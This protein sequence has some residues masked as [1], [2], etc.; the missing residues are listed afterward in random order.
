M[1]TET[2]SIEQLKQLKANFEQAH[3]DLMAAGKSGDYDKMTAAF[4]AEALAKTAVSRA[5]ADI[6][7]AAQAA[8]QERIMAIT[9]KA[10]DRIVKVC[11]TDL[12]ELVEQTKI[13]TLYIRY[14]DEAKKWSVDVTTGRTPRPTKSAG[15]S[16]GGGG[17][18][19]TYNGGKSSR[20]VLAEL[21]EAG[22]ED[23]QAAFARIEKAKA[24]G[25]FSPGFDSTLKKLIGAGLIT[26]DPETS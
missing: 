3:K 20:D 21:A 4:K 5:E 25:K 16:T 23:A 9:S 14:S 2:P 19:R 1:T 6:V 18:R 22:N 7:R 13:R 15:K 12:A 26:P 24:E 8:E 17:K 11:E 10:R